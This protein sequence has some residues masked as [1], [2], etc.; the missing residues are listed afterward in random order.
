MELQ[1]GKLNITIDG[2]FGSTGKG[3]LNSYL[4]KRPCNKIDIA[5]TNASP[6]A[7]HT[8]DLGEGRGKRTCFHLPVSAMLDKDTLIY[9]CAGSIIDPEILSKELTEFDAEERTFIHPRACILLPEHAEEERQNDSGPTGLASTQKGVGAAL[10]DKVRRKPGMRTAEQYYTSDKIKDIKLDTAIEEGSTI[11]MEVPQGF[12]LSINHGF[13]YPHCTSRDITVASALNDAGVHP[14]YLGRVFMSLRTLPIRVGHI[15]DERGKVL[16]HSGPFYE[17]SDERVWSEFGLE[18]ELTT[19]TKRVRRVATFSIAQYKRAVRM[20]RPDGIFINF[21][22]YFKHEHEFREIMVRI[23]VA[24]NQIFGNLGPRPEYAFG[25]GPKVT[26]VA[27]DPHVL[28]DIMYAEK[29]WKDEVN[30]PSSQRSFDFLEVYGTQAKAE[31]PQ[32][33]MGNPDLERI[34]GEA[35]G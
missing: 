16:G 4:A 15:Y 19:V 33:R 13:S 23:E 14:C 7:G 17:D 6:N 8:Y 35:T 9:L 27:P 10:A 21:C 32:G 22:N 18:P 31:R 28:R 24:N 20:L 3:V 34:A 1:K 12:D 26:D 11:L 2:Q 29:I 30:D 5:V 25:Y